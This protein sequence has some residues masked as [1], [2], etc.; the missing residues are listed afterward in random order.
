MK[1]STFLGSPHLSS[2]SINSICIWFIIVQM[3]TGDERLITATVVP[4]IAP[5]PAIACVAFIEF[6]TSG[7]TLS[8]FLTSHRYSLFT[9][10]PSTHFVHIVFNAKSHSNQFSTT[11]LSSQLLS[12]VVSFLAHLKPGSTAHLELQPSPLTSF[13]SSHWVGEALYFLPS[14]QMSTQTSGS[15]EFPSLQIQPTSIVQV[16]SH[17]SPR[18]RLPSSQ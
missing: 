9:S 5:V 12:R 7:A 15:V 14:P 8:S 4:A 13:P 11:H 3:I 17:P 10:K 16:S 18:S 2:V 1:S 6:F